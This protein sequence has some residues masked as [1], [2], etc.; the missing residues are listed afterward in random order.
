KEWAAHADLP[1]HV[2]QMICN[3]PNNLHP[4]AQFVS[5]IAALNCESKFAEAYSSGVKKVRYWEFV[6]DDAMKLLAKLPTIAALIYRNLYRDGKFLN[7]LNK[8][9]YSSM[10]M[11]LYLD[12]LYHFIGN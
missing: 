6:Y 10:N 11:Q 5:A 8:F 12:S 1:K 7:S 4:M 2:E 9:S 3:F